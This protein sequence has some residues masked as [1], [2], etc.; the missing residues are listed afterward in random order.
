MIN[1]SPRSI[2]LL[3][4]D[5]LTWY[6]GYVQNKREFEFDPYT[7][8]GVY[9]HKSLESWA[10]DNVYNEDEYL[11]QMKRE[12][13]KEGHPLEVDWIDFVKK[14]K[15]WIQNFRR[16]NYPKPTVAE[17]TMQYT[18]KNYSWYWLKIKVDWILDWLVWLDYK[19]VSKPTHS[20]KILDKY[21]EQTKIY[22][23]FM[24]LKTLQKF[25]WHIIEIPNEVEIDP[26]VY[27]FT[28]Y[29]WIIDEVEE[30]IHKSV[31]K[32]EWLKSLQID[33]VL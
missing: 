20:D 31:I 17:K 2:W 8:L 16:M 29:D 24:Y 27:Q 15:I 33:S 23:Y 26:L 5:N 4:T 6:K 30:L 21:S 1:L 18:L 3:R 28:W 32:A 10:K 22:S 14:F 19:F 9:C 12:F 11:H 7:T 25:N 13:E